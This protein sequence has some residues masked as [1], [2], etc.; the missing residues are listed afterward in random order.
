MNVLLKITFIPL[1]VIHVIVGLIYDATTWVFMLHEFV[2]LV[3]T[4]PNKPDASEKANQIVSQSKREMDALK[5]RA[6]VAESELFY[7]K[8]KYDFLVI[9]VEYWKL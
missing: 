9:L 5:S 2:R 4:L 3:G 8:S 1:I 7:L 6:N